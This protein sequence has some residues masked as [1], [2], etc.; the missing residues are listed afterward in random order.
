CQ[1]EFELAGQDFHN[2]GKR[3]NE[4]IVALR[5]LWTGG[6]QEFH[7][8]YYDFPPLQ[9]APVPPSPIPIY[10][11]GDSEPALKR[12]AA[13]GDGWIG[14]AYS[15]EDADAVLDRLHGHLKSRGRSIEGFE[16]VMALYV[17]PKPDV[18]RRFEDRGVT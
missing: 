17:E 12:A 1:E 15:I 4:M 14:N 2:R 13:L 18:L 16:T 11:G 5:S 7:G 6:W 3:L 8:S 9:I 10:L